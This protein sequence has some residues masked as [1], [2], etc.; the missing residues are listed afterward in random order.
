MEPLMLCK[1]FSVGEPGMYHRL[2]T[3][4]LRKL[5]TLIKR[6]K[7][8]RTSIMYPLSHL[9]HTTV[10]NAWR[11]VPRPHEYVAETKQIKVINEERCKHHLNGK[12]GRK[13]RCV[14]DTWPWNL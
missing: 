14:P 3:A 11:S 12:E 6:N 13:M 2:Y 10:A 9:V 4:M 1:M 5:P 7:D 8:A